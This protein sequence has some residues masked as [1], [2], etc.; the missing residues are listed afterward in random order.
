MQML[1]INMELAAFAVAVKTRMY[2][3]K[4]TNLK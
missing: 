3:K 4:D 2:H 1:Y